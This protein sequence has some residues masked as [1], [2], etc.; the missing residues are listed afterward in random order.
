MRKTNQSEL[1][2]R[3]SNQPII[4]QVPLT[5]L[6]SVSLTHSNPD[7]QWLDFYIISY[8][9]RAHRVHSSKQSNIRQTFVFF[10]ILVLLISSVAAYKTKKE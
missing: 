4:H 2:V 5:K 9:F 1:I 7:G 3:A 6:V 8:T 10:P